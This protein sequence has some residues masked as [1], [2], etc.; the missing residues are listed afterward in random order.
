MTPAPTIVSFLGTYSKLKA[1]VELTMIFSS[2]GIPGNGLGSLPVAIM[3]FVA[4]IISSFPSSL[5]TLISF[6][7][8]N[9]KTNY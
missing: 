8:I 2:K 9:K 7:I 1:P 6:L 3:I 4:L 5:I